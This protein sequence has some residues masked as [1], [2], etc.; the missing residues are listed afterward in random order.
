MPS[1]Y[2]NLKIQLMATG[3]NS[4][5]W[6]NVTNTNLGVALEEAITGTNT[7]TFA[8]NNQTLSLSDVNTTLPARNLRLRCTGTTANVTRSLIVPTLTTDNNV[9]NKAYIVQNDTDGSIL[10]KTAAGNGVTIPNGKSTWVY[11]N[12][13]DVVEAFTFANNLA[14]TTLNATTVNVTTVNLAAPLPA[15]SGGTGTNAVPTAGQVLV[16]TGTGYNAVS[17]T[18]G[19]GITVVANATTFNISTTVSAYPGAGVAVSTGSAWGTSKTT[20]T[21]DLVGT[22]DTQTLTNKT[23]SGVNTNSTILDNGG[24]SRII[25]YRQVPQNAQSS[26]YTLVLA[27]DGKHIYSTNSGAQSVTIPANAS[28]AFPTGTAVV[29]VNNGTTAITVNAASVTLYQ[30]GTTNTGNRTVAA[31]GMATLLKVDTDTW[32]V[33]GAGVS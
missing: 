20:P 16:G 2:S 25:G 9:Y 17:V 18:T 21:G 22:T 27:D 19:T 4:T 30:A 5:T 11:A 32:F 10:V 28:V 24:A 29:I 8:N 13:T 1:T 12:G 7:V 3:E 31:R 15:A 26:N 14:V 23:L 33:S 6:G